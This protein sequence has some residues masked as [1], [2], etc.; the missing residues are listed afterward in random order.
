M[1]GD[2]VLIGAA[3][4]LASAGSWAL[5][6]VL[7]RRLG[8]VLAPVTLTAAKGVVGAAMLL[9]VFWPLATAPVAPGTWALLGGSGLL[10][11]ALGD[12]L[13]FM[14]LNRLGAQAVVLLLTLGQVL[15]VLLAVFWLGER[16]GAAGWTGI[17]LVISGVTAVM[18]L[19]MQAE[20]G[21]TQRTGILCGL[22]AVVCMAV[23]I[24]IAKQAL[25]AGENSVQ[26]TLIRMLAGTAGAVALGVVSGQKLGQLV[27]AFRPEFALFFLLSV[28]VVTFGG[29]WLS[30]F[31]I[32][33][34]GVAIASTLGSL[35]PVLVLPF[36]A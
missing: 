36:A 2:G 34:A 22:G 6:S 32:Q 31:A 30:L 25:E 33:H 9:L 1:E 23:S 28:A 8:D 20:G 26:A 18:W 14:A 3:A 29:F 24:V 12:T 19:R 15:T 17:A 7:F 4:A 11:I 16:P 10:G 5:G 13:F 35:E 21:Q 27:P